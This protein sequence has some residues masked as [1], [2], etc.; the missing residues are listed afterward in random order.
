MTGTRRWASAG[1]VTHAPFRINPVHD[2][3]RL[4]AQFRERG[5]LHIPQFLDGDGADRLLDFLEAGAVWN[6]VLNSGDTL[7]ELDAAAQAALTPARRAQLD[8]AVYANAR[9]GFQYRYE[10]MRVPDAE[11]ERRARG[12]PLDAFALFLSDERTLAFLRTVVGAPDLTFADAQA[13]A[14][15][16]GH[17]LTAHD[18]DVAGKSRRAAFVMN[19]T[20]E[21]S[22]DW[23]GLLAFH[24][25]GE[26]AAEALVPTF[27]ALNL[28]AVPQVHSVTM[29]APFAAHRRYSVTG[30]LRSGPR[31]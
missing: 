10:T 29:V 26:A 24:T 15:G 7:F 30:W 2:P 4:A 6:L 20:R 21:W 23:G 9:R 11:A 27:N 5:R 13:T 31:P 19:L 16:P 3:D 8:E 22:T 14:Y 25:P 28:F 17:L 18:D 1:R 12:T